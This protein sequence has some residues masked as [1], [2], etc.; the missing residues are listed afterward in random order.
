MN[1]MSAGIDGALGY[2]RRLKEGAGPRKSQPGTVSEGSGWSPPSL[3]R[4][5]CLKVLVI[6]ITVR[7]F[8]CSTDT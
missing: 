1:L 3:S 4:M 8:F 6:F 7:D 2:A 5:A